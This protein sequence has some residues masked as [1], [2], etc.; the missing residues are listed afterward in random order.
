MITD[1]Q[2]RIAADNYCKEWWEKEPSKGKIN[3][4]YRAGAKHILSMKENEAVEFGEFLKKNY[5]PYPVDGGRLWYDIKNEWK[6]IREVKMFTTF[7]LYNIF[8]QSKIK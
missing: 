5:V 1:E 6:P 8:K 2:I 7:E 4:G 3:L